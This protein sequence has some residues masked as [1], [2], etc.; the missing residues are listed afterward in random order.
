MLGQ[1]DDFNPEECVVEIGS[2]RGEGST[3]WL[4]KF[5]IRRKIHFHT[6]DVDPG[7]YK[8]A[9]K[10]FTRYKGGFCHAHFGRGE[11]F[12]AN[13][14]ELHIR[15]AYLDSFDCIPSGLEHEPFIEFYRQKYHDLGMVMTNANSQAVHLI[16]ASLVDMRSASRCA[17]LIDDTWKTDDAWDGKGALAI[18]YLQTRG[19]EIRDLDGAQLAVRA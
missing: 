11:D 8:G 5:C 17:I 6:I 12:L 19:F 2:E 7:V 1:F 10:I 15:F 13:N 9:E 18:P 16:Q 4:A 14:S 3:T